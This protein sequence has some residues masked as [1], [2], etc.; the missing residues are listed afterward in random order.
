MSLPHYDSGPGLRIPPP[1]LGRPPVPGPGH[2]RNAPT[3]P[4]PSLGKAA[5]IAVLACCGVLAIAAGPV[6]PFLTGFLTTITVRIWLRH[7]TP[8]R[9]LR[10]G[11]APA[12]RRAPA[13]RKPQ[14]RARR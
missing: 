12:R 9:S 13:K 11:P 3:P 6:G 2:A 4:R 8:N 7:Q 1:R 14:R 5:A 10:R